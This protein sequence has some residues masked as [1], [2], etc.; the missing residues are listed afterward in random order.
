MRVADAGIPG[1]EGKPPVKVGLPRADQNHSGF[2]QFRGSRGKP[3]L[4]RSE[5][6][7][8]REAAYPRTNALAV[9]PPAPHVVNSSRGPEPGISLRRQG[10]EGRWASFNNTSISSCLR[11][12]PAFWYCAC[13]ASLDGGPE[14]S[15][16]ANYLCG[17]PGLRRK[18][19]RL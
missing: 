7:A 11:W 6:Q 15:G 13:A 5:R 3:E 17:A 14:T 2:P 19:H 1:G 8:D 4:S 12:L 16:G 18:R 10:A 9:V